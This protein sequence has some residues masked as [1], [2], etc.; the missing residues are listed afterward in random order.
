MKTGMP[1]IAFRFSAERLMVDITEVVD[2]NASA[3]VQVVRKSNIATIILWS[4]SNIYA[5]YLPLR[6]N[7]QRPEPDRRPFQAANGRTTSSTAMTGRAS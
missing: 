2:S 7:R 5:T 3:G 6:S 4:D 1:M